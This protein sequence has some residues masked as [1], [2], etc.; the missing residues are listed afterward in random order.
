MSH[1]L[2]RQGTYESLSDDFVILTSP[3]RKFE[4]LPA[5][6]SRFREIGFHHGA[7]NV[8]GVQSSTSLRHLVYDNRENMCRT[9][10]DLEKAELGL[11]VMVSGLRDQ[12]GG[13]CQ[14]IGLKPHTVN[15]SLGLWGRTEKLPPF[16]VLEITTMCGHGRVAPSLVWK[17]ADGV[18]RQSLDVKAAGRQMGKLCLCNIFNEVR[19]ARLLKGLVANIEAGIIALPAIPKKRAAIKYFG[20]TIDDTRCTSCLECLPY[21]PVGAIVESSDGTGVAID[22]ERCTECG[23]CRQAKVCPVDAI[24]GMDLTWPRSLRGKFQQPYAPYRSVP[25]LAK[26]SMAV[27]YSEEGFVFRRNEFPS[28]HTNDVTGLLG[29]GEAVIMVELGRPHLGA[30]FRDVQKLLQTLG[31]LGLDLRQQYPVSDE[32]SSMAEI[33]ASSSEGVLLPEILEER[34][35]WVVLKMVA[36]E[37]K[38]SETVRRLQQVA[39]EIDTIF[40]LSIVSRVSK[41][42][43]TIAERVASE[44]GVS[45]AVTC[46]TNVGL[47]RP[48]AEE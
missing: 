10:K 14:S 18:K 41:D 37:R 28:E 46:K 24:V 27:S 5:R 26:A 21:C 40:G 2:Y 17:M 48:L 45:P 36:P 3:G 32:R 11:S 15:Q 13:C 9:L 35:G 42:G 30:T 8:P 39:Q 12:V 38:V 23:L 22:A 7:V 47:G 25:G 1:S 43:S 34:A 31:P 16:P 19:A 4:D 33:V 29:Q 20:I 44:T 6:V